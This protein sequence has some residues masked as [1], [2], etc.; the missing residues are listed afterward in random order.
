[1]SLELIIPCYK[2]FT[3]SGSS[4]FYKG[5]KVPPLRF[6]ETMVS[7]I[8]FQ[9]DTVPTSSPMSNVPRRSHPTPLSRPYPH[10]RKLSV[11]L[12]SRQVH[13]GSE[14]DG[15]RLLSPL[16]QVGGSW[17]RPP[18][19]SHGSPTDLWGERNPG[20]Q[21]SGFP[22]RRRTRDQSLDTRRVDHSRY[23]VVPVKH[24]PRD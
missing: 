14:W 7:S 5:S 12:A 9:K 17:Y 6:P 1:M 10:H 20:R 11:T 15:T 4:P 19:L 24:S 22:G 21:G 3:G 16:R 23:T 2:R 18:Y 13:R 8:P